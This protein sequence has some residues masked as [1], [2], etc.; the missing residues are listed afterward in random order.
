MA[1]DTKDNSADAQAEKTA[2]GTGEEM[3]PTGTDTVSAE[4]AAETQDGPATGEPSSPAPVEPTPAAEPA[5]PAAEPT[6]EPAPVGPTEA[7]LAAK[8]A[9][10]DEA[11]AAKAEEDRQA[12]VAKAIEDAA[13][14][15]KGKIAKLSKDGVAMSASMIYGEILCDTARRNHEHH[16]VQYDFSQANIDRAVRVSVESAI[17]LH[18][19]LAAEL[20]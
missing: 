2:P 19:A 7:E 9:A 5:A 3:T 10:D 1:E 18:L 8:K 20:G 4:P 11:A 13:K 16:G 12:A 14:A 6:P 15:R 17:E